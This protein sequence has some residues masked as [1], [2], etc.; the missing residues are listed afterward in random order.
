MLHTIPE[1]TQRARL[2][3]V[4]AMQRKLIEEMCALPADATVDEAWLRGIWP[5]PP[6]KWVRRFWKN[7]NGNR[8][9]WCATIAKATTAE[10][11]AILT[12]FAEKTEQLK[13]LKATLIEEARQNPDALISTANGG[14]R[15][16]AEGADGCI[17]RVSFPAA[18]LISELDAK[19]DLTEQCQSLA[20]E[21]FRKLFT[22]VKFYQL[23]EDFRAEAKALLPATKAAELTKLCEN[24]A[25]PRVSFETAKEK[26]A[27]KA[28][29]K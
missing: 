2:L 13:L 28:K 24:E 5:N 15:W 8:A 18:T 29:V 16:S 10:K 23:A 3:E 11:A 19:G 21:S 22:V 6:R 12:M 20:G 17:A 27:A 7:D 1:S 25:A 9:V 14:T 4:V 26:P